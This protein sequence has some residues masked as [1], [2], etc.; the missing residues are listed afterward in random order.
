MINRTS[1]LAAEFWKHGKTR[2]CPVIDMHGHMGPFRGIYFPRASTADMVKTLDEC[3]VRM[4]VFCHHEALFC[5]EIGNTTAIEAVRKYP[6]HLR[7]Y[8]G[9]L[10]HH[11][12]QIARDLATYDKYRDVYVGLKFLAGYFQIPWDA[13]VWECAWQFANERKL[14]VLGHTWGGSQHDGPG[15]VRKAAEK[16]PDIKLLCGHSMFG[17]WDEAVAVARDLPN[18]YLE[19]TA[20]LSYRGPLEKFVDAGLVD[21]ILFGT[22]L[23]WFDPHQGIGA[24]LSADITDE[25][26]HK[27]LHRNAEKL[28]KGVGVRISH[29]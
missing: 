13:K 26:R 28:L 27:I 5:P 4:L 18:V 7:A 19:L 23:P 2:S 8:L 20:L 16:Y 17:A 29:Q 12:E 6:K 14:I 21:R 15:Q 22:D 25:D 1:K 11:P 10:P 9:L 3:G 24:V